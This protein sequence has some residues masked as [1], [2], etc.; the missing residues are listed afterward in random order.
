V[1]K[2]QLVN[3]TATFKIIAAGGQVLNPVIGFETLSTH[4]K[5]KEKLLNL[6]KEENIS[7]VIFLTGDRHQTEAMKLE[8]EGTYPLYE[9]T[10]SPFT[11]GVYPDGDKENN[12]LR[13]SGTLVAQRNF[14]IFQ[15]YGPASDREL[16]CSVYDSKGE[17]IWTQFI[18]ASEL[19]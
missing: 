5:E 11:S 14:A 19:K 8:R 16:K 7:G 6:I 3:S 17:L 12:T 15:V 13:I 1:Y 10:I 4:P 9:F 18:K 2:R